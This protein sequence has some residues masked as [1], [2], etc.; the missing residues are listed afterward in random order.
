MILS[1]HE[2]IL[3]SHK[4]EDR[5]TTHEKKYYKNIHINT[6]ISTL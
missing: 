1:R 3:V 6:T 2:Y 4:T 5:F